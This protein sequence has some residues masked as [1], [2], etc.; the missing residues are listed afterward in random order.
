MSK[1]ESSQPKGL[2]LAE[3]GVEST[4]PSGAE[5]LHQ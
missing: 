1:G 2:P 5:D 4:N 3:G